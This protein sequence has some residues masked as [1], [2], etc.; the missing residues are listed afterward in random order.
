MVRTRGADLF[1]SALHGTIGKVAPDRIWNDRGTINADLSLTVDGIATPYPADNSPGAYFLDL[2][3]TIEPDA[4]SVSVPSRQTEPAG[5]G[6][7]EHKVVYPAVFRPPAPG[8]RVAVQWV[9][10]GAGTA[11]IPVV[12]SIIVRAGSVTSP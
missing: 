9:R 4:V 8:D 2:R 3:L 5:D 6:P 7:H 1:N 11:G 12:T 10:D